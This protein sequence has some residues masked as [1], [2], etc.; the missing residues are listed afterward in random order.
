MIL[1][2]A[3]SIDQIYYFEIENISPIDSPSISKFSPISTTGLSTV[4]QTAE[5]DILR[6]ASKS[7]NSLGN[8]VS[9]PLLFKSVLYNNDLV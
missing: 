6:T 8:P 4:T 5:P 1:S 3:S 7:L 2:S 9:P